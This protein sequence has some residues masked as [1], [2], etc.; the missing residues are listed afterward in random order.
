M[1][2]MKFIKNTLLILSLP[3]FV[4][5]SI[6]QPKRKLYA[7]LYG[8][9]N[10]R[11]EDTFKVTLDIKGLKQEN[12]IFQFASTAPGTYQVMDIGRFV[13]NFQAFDKDGNPMEITKLSK[14]YQFHL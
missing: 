4:A 10:D 6:F 1:N 5:C 8:N 12:N 11:S 14:S 13:K 2:K 9:L 7:N 3:L